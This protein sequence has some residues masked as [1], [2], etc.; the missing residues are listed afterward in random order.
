MIRT[1][2][3]L[4]I[5][6]ALAS[7]GRAQSDESSADTAD[8]PA[9]KRPFEL[10]QAELDNDAVSE[11]T[12]AIEANAS[13]G[14]YVKRSREFARAGQW[15][16]AAADL[17]SAAEVGDSA[18]RRMQAGI[19]LLLAKD[20]MSY[21]PLVEDMLER[22]KESGSYYRTERTVKMC[23]LPTDPIVMRETAFEMI[24]RAVRASG[25]SPWA[26]YFPSTQAMV[27][28]RYGKH[29]EALESI[30][31]SDRL[32]ERIGPSQDVTAIN[33][34]LE[35]LCRAKLGDRDKAQAAYDHGET[36]LCEVFADPELIRE[37]GFWTDFLIAELLR[38]EAD[39]VLAKAGAEKPA[40]Q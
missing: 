4:A 29:S 21:Q 30:A 34:F 1:L 31:S 17:R 7:A 24:D 9:L 27:R 33:R 40:K 5:L 6:F 35:A 3:S 10:P 25:S 39:S 14:L 20:R 13:E 22:F 23:V 32:N 28:Y 26:Q 16:K 2:T 11:L 12:R 36:I 37:H 15:S 18:M 38:R 19:C 8:R